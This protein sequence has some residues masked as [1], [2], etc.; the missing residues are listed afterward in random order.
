MITHVELGEKAPDSANTVTLGTK[1]A[2]NLDQ[3]AAIAVYMTTRGATGGIS[4][5]TLQVSHGAGKWWDWYRTADIAA[6][7]AA[8]T[9]KVTDSEG[10]ASSTPVGT[11][12]D[13]AATPLLEKGTVAPGC[14]GRKMRAVFENDAGVTVGG[15]HDITVVGIRPS[16]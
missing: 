14:W 16:G 10:D 8:T 9:F 1:V 7:A 6:G 12:T 15:T 5:V 11:G 3:F 4:R 13:N 2:D